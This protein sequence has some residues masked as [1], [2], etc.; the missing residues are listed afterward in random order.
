M[1]GLSSRFVASSVDD[2]IL[3]P[4][5]LEAPMQTRFDQL[6]AAIRAAVTAG[7]QQYRTIADAV[8]EV[9]EPATIPDRYG[10]RDWGRL[11]D[12][13]L[14][15]LRK[16]GVLVFAGRR[17]AVSPSAPPTVPK[18][19]ATAA[20]HSRH[21]GDYLL[22]NRADGTAW[23]AASIAESGTWRAAVNPNPVAMLQAVA[24]GTARHLH[25]GG[26]PDEAN[27]P[28]ARDPE[29]PVCAALV[30]LASPSKR[31]GDE[32]ARQPGTEALG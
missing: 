31:P 11:V 23:Q 7:N 13:R 21:L 3:N 15:A 30:V 18:P 8:R 25:R 28:T 19:L 22:L 16:A 32:G 5:A 29:C 24:E 1:S 12:R 10:Q 9:A 26:C 27:G 14:Q 17:W 20:V 2:R 4:D 6:D